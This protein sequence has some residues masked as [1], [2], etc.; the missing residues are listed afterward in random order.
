MAAQA[1]SGKSHKE[2]QA[3]DSVSSNEKIARL[4]AVIATKDIQQAPERVTLLRAIGFTVPEVASILGMSENHVS[5][6]TH[7]GRNKAKRKES[8]KKK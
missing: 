4:L 7:L 8:Q 6:A 3:I 5:V 1:K 2:T